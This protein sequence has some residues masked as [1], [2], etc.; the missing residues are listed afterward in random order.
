MCWIIQDLLEV[1]MIKVLVT[2]FTSKLS[3][4]IEKSARHSDVSELSWFFSLLNTSKQWL[5]SISSIINPLQLHIFISVILFCND[6]CMVCSLVFSFICI[7]TRLP[8]V[9]CVWEISHFKKLYSHLL[10]NEMGTEITMLSSGFNIYE[11]E[12]TASPNKNHNQ[13]QKQ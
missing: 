7:K 11:I 10:S 2:W 9:S 5:T 6:N 8:C 4:S 13:R 12:N 3:C 1:W